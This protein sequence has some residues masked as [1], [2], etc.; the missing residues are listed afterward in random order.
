MKMKDHANLALKAVLNAAAD[1]Y[2][3]TWEVIDEV[4]QECEVPRE[5]AVQLIA[6]LRDTLKSYP[7]ILYFKSDKIYDAEVEIDI[8]ELLT[9]SILTDKK[10]GDGPPYYFIHRKYKWN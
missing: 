9:E 7:E 4:A 5:K 3:P 6:K 10:I 1:G 2:S 8:D